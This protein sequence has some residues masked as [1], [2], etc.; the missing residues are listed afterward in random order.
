[1]E[2][3]KDGVLRKSNGFSLGLHSCALSRL[4]FRSFPPSICGDPFRLRSKGCT[5]QSTGGIEAL[6]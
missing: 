5:L 6:S 3:A 4:L 1:M 2:D